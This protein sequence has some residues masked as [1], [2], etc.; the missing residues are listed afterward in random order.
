MARQ[1]GI[2]YSWHETHYP[3]PGT[4]NFAFLP[5]MTLP[6]LAVQGPG[7]LVLGQ[8]GVVSPNEFFTQ[9]TVPTSGLGGIQQGQIVGQSLIGG[10]DYNGSY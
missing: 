4:G 8:M 1:S 2:P 7:N 10:D 6:A 9:P 5:N 3:S